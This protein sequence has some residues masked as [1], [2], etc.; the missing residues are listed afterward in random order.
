MN[1][2]LLESVQKVLTLLVNGD[3]GQIEQITKGARIGASDIKRAIEDYGRTLVTA[4]VE[5]MRLWDVVAVRGAFPPRW[6]VTVPLWTL[7]EGRSDLSVGLTL[8]EEVSG[9]EI[10][11]DDIHVL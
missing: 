5:S 7:E 9:V 6:N 3:Y 11:F 10:A 8:V 4:P 2:K 1:A